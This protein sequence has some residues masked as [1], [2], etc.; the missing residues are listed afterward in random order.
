MVLSREQLKSLSSSKSTLNE[1]FLFNLIDR[2]VYDPNNVVNSLSYSDNVLSIKKDNNQPESLSI[3]RGDVVKLDRNKVTSSIT[4]DESNEDYASV[5]I[6]N[7]NDKSAGNFN[8]TKNNDPDKDLDKTKI[9]SKIVTD[10]SSST[11][12]VHKFYDYSGSTT[13]KIIELP[14]S[15]FVSKYDPSKVLSYVGEVNK[16]DSMY[17]HYLFESYD[18]SKNYTIDLPKSV[19]NSMMFSTF[20]SS[21]YINL[22]LAYRQSAMAPMNI[23]ASDPLDSKNIGYHYN[24]GYNSSIPKSVFSIKKSSS[25]SY[26]LTKSFGTSSINT[27]IIE[28]NNS[29]TLYLYSI[30]E[31]DNT[32]KA[33]YSCTLN[34]NKQDL[35]NDI[36]FNN[37]NI[38]FKKE[39]AI[40]LKAGKNTFRLY[41]SGIGAIDTNQ[42]FFRQ[43]SGDYSSNEAFKKQKSIDQYIGYS[44]VFM[45]SFVDMFTKSVSI[46][47]IIRLGKSNNV[48]IDIYANS[49][50]NKAPF[51]QNKDTDLSIDVDYFNIPFS[52]YATYTGV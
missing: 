27:N 50:L 18:K 21:L 33:L 5:D 36:Y 8:I 3:N 35:Y 20:K 45:F 44:T 12:T 46:K 48:Y 43:V 39:N 26:S 30:D 1:N 23:S 52:R 22:N 42:L 6:T 28:N 24:Q 10:N 29:S 14:K 38:L 49:L 13:P 2:T 40:P 7:Y 4:K 47:S 11:K 15:G 19:N 17:V 37:F 51:E 41:N 25:S 31:N 32:N 9:M 16:D 34:T